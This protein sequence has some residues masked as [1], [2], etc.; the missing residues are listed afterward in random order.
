MTIG[1]SQIPE[2]IDAFD[3]GGDASSATQEYISQ[4]KKLYANKPDVDF[5]SV[6]GRAEESARVFGGGGYFIVP[7]RGDQL[8]PRGDQLF[9]WRWS[10]CG[11]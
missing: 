2:Q 1:R 8:S 7:P 5:E 9:A 10:L 6:Q 4:L 3:E 11:R